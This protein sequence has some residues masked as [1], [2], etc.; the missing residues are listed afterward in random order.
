MDTI[1]LRKMTYKSQFKGGKCEDMTVHQALS[2]HHERYLRY[3]YFNYASIT[4]IDEILDIINIPDE[5][6]IKKPGINKKFHTILNNKYNKI[7]KAKQEQGKH[8][9]IRAYDKFKTRKRRIRKTDSRV[10]SKSSLQN[11]NHG[12]KKL[13]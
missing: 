12:H 6:R 9:F 7:L 10:F 2:L 1:Y 11:A 3:C 4:F 13:R 5:F 8:S